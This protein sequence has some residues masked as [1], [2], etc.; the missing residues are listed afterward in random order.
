MLAQ[1]SKGGGPSIEPRAGAMMLSGIQIIATGIS[2]QTV[3]FIGRRPLLFYG[4][5]L[6]GVLHATV[7]LFNM[8]DE[9]LGVLITLLVWMMVY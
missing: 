3:A 4:H 2:S 5:I 9:S 8:H 7:A 6:M 1:M